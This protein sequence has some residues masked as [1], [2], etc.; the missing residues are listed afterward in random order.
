M[1]R[2]AILAIAVALL[3]TVAGQMLFKAAAMAMNGAGTVVAWRPALFF[4][5]AVA[6][7]GAMSVMWTLALR[8][9][10]LNRAYPFMAA[11]FLIVPV[12]ER[13]IFGQDLPPQALVGGAI[14]AAGIVVT[15]L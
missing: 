2:F 4:G 11:C 8:E 3:G 12:V 1:S 15:Q 5:L 7:Y 9:V 6:L 14:I 13:L 10:P